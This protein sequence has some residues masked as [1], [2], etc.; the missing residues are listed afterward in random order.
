MSAF[1]P[2]GRHRVAG[3]PCLP[4]VGVIAAMIVL[5]ER[6]TV[7]DTIGFALM[8]SA[9]AVVLLKPDGAAQA[10]R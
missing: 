7:Y 10:S 5:G 4:V 1:A 3:H 9:S 2:L 8:L 6:P